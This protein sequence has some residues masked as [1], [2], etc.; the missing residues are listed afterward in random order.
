M[1]AI[2]TGEGT[3]RIFCRFAENSQIELDPSIFF[4]RVSRSFCPPRTRKIQ[5]QQSNFLTDS[6]GYRIIIEELRAGALG[7]RAVSSVSQLAAVETGIH[8]VIPRPWLI[9]ESTMHH[10]NSTGWSSRHS[11]LTDGAEISTKS[12][13]QLFSWRDYSSCH[14]L[15]ARGAR[16]SLYE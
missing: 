16:S 10:E 11:R 9:H 8:R 6:H 1:N 13:R 2:F 14:N 3:Y 7:R 15:Y 5:P 4:F 12:N